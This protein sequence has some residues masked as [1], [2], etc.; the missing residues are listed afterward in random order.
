MV[1]RSLLRW[2]LSYWSNMSHVII[3][4]VSVSSTS[5]SGLIS[6]QRFPWPYQAINKHY[7]HKWTHNGSFGPLGV[8]MPIPWLHYSNFHVLLA[9]YHQGG[10]ITVFVLAA[11]TKLF[12]VAMSCS[13]LCYVLLKPHLMSM[14]FIFLCR[15]CWE[16]LGFCAK[17]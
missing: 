7:T 12:V 4:E 17:I 6:F 14:G 10:E 3:S 5:A 2:S 15:M 13:I 16:S 8:P 11:S 9:M 1:P